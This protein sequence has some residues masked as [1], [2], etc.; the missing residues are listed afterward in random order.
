MLKLIKNHLGPIYQ[1]DNSCY[2]MEDCEV[3]LKWYKDC[4]YKLFFALKK[5]K[6][7]YSLN[8]L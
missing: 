5:I 3:L 6:S 8:L 7:A 2:C 1:D 4:V